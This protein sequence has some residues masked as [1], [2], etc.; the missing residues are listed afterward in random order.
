MTTRVVHV[1]DQVEG[2]VYIGR[3]VPR[4]KIRMSRL[5]NPYRV[6][7]NNA[8]LEGLELTREEAVNKYRT[9]IMHHNPML[10][11]DLPALRGKP[12]ACWC[13]H[14][15]EERT[16]DNLCHGDVL[17]FLL[18]TYTDAELRELALRAPVWGATPEW[19]CGD[20]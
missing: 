16:P 8:L 3:A 4:Q 11:A 18:D 20:I 2:A 1:N 12:L 5:A 10:L 13:R 6:G 7:A 9:W 17:L 14:D 19:G 15:G